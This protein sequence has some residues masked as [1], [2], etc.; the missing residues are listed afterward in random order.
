M[1]P[2]GL[3]QAIV[4]TDRQASGAN[5]LSETHPAKKSL[6]SSASKT[7]A[8]LPFWQMDK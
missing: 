6:S 3:K 8:A 4:R 7:L 1:I 2:S 5:V